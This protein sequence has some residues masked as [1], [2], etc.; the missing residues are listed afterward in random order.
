MIKLHIIHVLRYFLNL[1]ICHI[2]ANL[3][4]KN[5]CICKKKYITV[6]YNMPR[7]L[8]NSLHTATLSSTSTTP[9][10]VDVLLGFNNAFAQKVREI[11]LQFGLVLTPHTFDLYV[12]TSSGLTIQDVTS[13]VTSFV[14]ASSTLNETSR[15]PISIPDL[16]METTGFVEFHAVYDTN[17]EL[18]S[19]SLAIKS[20]KAPS[21]PVLIRNINNTFGIPDGAQISLETVAQ[22]SNAD[23][24]SNITNVTFIFSENSTNPERPPTVDSFTLPYTYSVEPQIFTITDSF[25][26]SSNIEYNVTGFYTNSKGRSPLFTKFTIVS[27]ALPNPVGVADSG[28][29]IVSEDGIKPNLFLMGSFPTGNGSRGAYLNANGVD[30]PLTVIN[31]FKIW[32]K[33]TVEGPYTLL[34]TIAAPE[35]GNLFGYVYDVKNGDIDFVPGQEYFLKVTAVSD[36]GEGL[37]ND[38]PVFSMVY[39]EMPSEA[40]NLNAVVNS[41]HTI[42]LSW[43]PPQRVGHANTLGY[44]GGYIWPGTTNIGFTVGNGNGTSFTIPANQ[45]FPGLQY[46]FNITTW[47]VSVG[48]NGLAGQS[49]PSTG[50]YNFYVA[51]PPDNT[52]S[53]TA[54][55]EDQ[56]VLFEWVPIEDGSLNNL[57]FYG[58]KIVMTNTENGASTTQLITDKSSNSYNFTDLENGVKY[59][60]SFAV[61]T[62]NTQDN[63]RIHTSNSLV[64]DVWPFVAPSKPQNVTALTDL[65]NLPSINITWEAPVNGDPDAA[66]WCGCV[67]QNYTITRTCVEDNENVAYIDVDAL[68]TAYTDNSGNIGNSYTYTVSVT[69]SNPNYPDDTAYDVTSE[70]SEPTNAALAFVAPRP[71]A[72]NLL[73]IPTPGNNQITLNWSADTGSE[74]ECGLPTVGYFI[75]LASDSSV[76][77]KVNALT[78]TLTDLTNGTSYTYNIS[79]YV[80]YNGVEV[81]S[82]NNTPF[83]V[84]IPYTNPDPVTALG[85]VSTNT[86]SNPKNTLSWVLPTNTG[87]FPISSIQVYKSNSSSMAAPALLSPALPVNATSLVDTN[88]VIG[89]NYTYSVEVTTTA[90]EAGLSNVSMNSVQETVQGRP[91]APPVINSLTLD[92]DKNIVVNMTQNGAQVFDY[93]M[94]AVPD[95]ATSAA[96]AEIKQDGHPVPPTPLNGDNSPV[97]FIIDANA[98]SFAELIVV[99][100]NT[101]G[102]GYKAQGQLSSSGVPP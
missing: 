79:P 54:S 17:Y 40:R 37:L 71:L 89:Y 9:D 18:Y 23:G 77:M 32:L 87:G 10:K 14:N 62:I 11:C 98:E 84:S 58:Y 41:D 95:N 39:Y 55:P 74:A 24:F 80:V 15:I 75:R 8:L 46:G 20:C 96:Q 68:L 57:D 21:A 43:D 78:T 90:V 31:S 50:Y 26:F 34:E 70:L 91:S 30:D 102:M 49:A 65:S 86:L 61:Q 33:T 13:V 60:W 59:T 5:Y 29:L 94:F 52:E 7:L 44:T 64:G 85:C 83:T 82:L 28:R 2:I 47:V 45:V 38:S 63:D 101:A 67:L 3:G 51:F 93:L 53:V 25:S 92:A 88:V 22:N 56:S 48:G 16:P 4:I 35:S 97:T 19:N 73:Q 42:T 100:S 81:E 6:F 69:A 12:M 27:G 99:V 76:E 66:N 1:N 36:R 72:A